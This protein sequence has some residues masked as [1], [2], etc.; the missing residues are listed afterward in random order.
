MHRRIAASPATATK[1][2]AASSVSC[3]VVIAGWYG[4][5]W[6][7]R[8]AIF[9]EGELCHRPQRVDRPTQQHRGHPRLLPDVELVADLL[10]RTDEADLLDHLRRHGR[11]GL[12]LLPVQ[13]QLLDA[14]RL[15]LVTQTAEHV[16]M[17]VHLAGTHPA[18][19]ERQHR[20]ERVGGALDVVVDDH[21]DGGHHLELVGAATR[22]GTREAFVERLAVE[23]LVSG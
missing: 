22:A 8:R 21:G 23:V 17:E 13:E 3:R 18:D 11:D 6:P 9:S 10:L 5:V 12:V 2:W 14:T 20:A 7:R 1:Y 16:I 15:R 19:V 4:G